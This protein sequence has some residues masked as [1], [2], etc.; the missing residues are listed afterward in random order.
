MD[1]IIKTTLTTIIAGGVGYFTAWLK[2]FADAEKS[3]SDELWKLRKEKY[4]LLWVILKKMPKWPARKDFTF[5]NLR[6]LSDEMKDWYFEE[7][8]MLLTT[9]SVLAYRLLQER[10]A[11]YYEREQELEKL[12]DKNDYY[13]IIN[14][15]SKLRTQLTRDLLSRKRLFSR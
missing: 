15:C 1:E 3:I 2:Y 8:G 12:M 11:A 4:Q 14:L 5:Q 6:T 9:E 7:G 10:M 13:I